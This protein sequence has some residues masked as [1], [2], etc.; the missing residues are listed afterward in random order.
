MK[1]YFLLNNSK[2]PITLTTISNHD[3]SRIDYCV[4]IYR[5]IWSYI[6][7]I[8]NDRRKITCRIQNIHD[9]IVK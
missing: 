7:A 9:V 4:K 5:N 1:N 2:R 6:A 3:R 8:S